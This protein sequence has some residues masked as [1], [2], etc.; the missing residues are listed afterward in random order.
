VQSKTGAGAEH[1][2]LRDRMALLRDEAASELRRTPE[3]APS[4]HG[5]CS[6]EIYERRATMLRDPIARMRY[7]R[8]WHL[9]ELVVCSTR[10]LVALDAG[11]DAAVAVDQTD[12]CLEELGREAYRALHHKAIEQPRRLVQQAARA[13]H[14]AERPALEDRNA[15]LCQEAERLWAARPGW[16]TQ[17]VAKQLAR[18]SVLSARRIRRII[19]PVRKKLAV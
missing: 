8:W 12:R 1:Q 9:R 7:N 2:A 14:A 19:A 3:P 10:A 17:A 15:V 16:S 4:P 13:R 6:D 5:L 11:E 18:T